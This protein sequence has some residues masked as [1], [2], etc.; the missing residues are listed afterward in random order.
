M[1]IGSGF[2]SSFTCKSLRNHQPCILKIISYAI[3]YDLSQFKILFG[4]R[5]KLLIN[6]LM[7]SS[8]VILF[9]NI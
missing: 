2:P 7:Q 6:N 1:N 8:F 5:R 4:Q 3:L 9:K